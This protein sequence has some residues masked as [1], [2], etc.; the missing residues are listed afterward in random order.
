MAR[1]RLNQESHDLVNLVFRSCAREVTDLT[2]EGAGADMSGHEL[3]VELRAVV[4]GDLRFFGAWA[5]DVSA[6]LKPG[7]YGCTGVSVARGRQ[8]GPGRGAGDDTKAGDPW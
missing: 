4:G 8:A 7:A 6:A 5:S 3:F 2:L 1:G